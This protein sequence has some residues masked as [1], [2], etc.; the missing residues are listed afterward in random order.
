MNRS[1]IAL[2]C[3]AIE[4]ALAFVLP[5][6]GLIWSLFGV[7]QLF[8]RGHVT[9]ASVLEPGLFVGAGGAGFFGLF[10]MLRFL[11]TGTARLNR[12]VMSVCVLAGFS[13]AS[14]LAAD[15]VVGTND[16][17]FASVFIAPLVSG[18]HLLYL[19]RSYF[20]TASHIP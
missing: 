17:F 3:V 14:W 19:G 4:V 2:A 10:H 11:L 15:A 1:A 6:M 13:L 18:L 12:I 7:A 5:L 8:I 9:Q 16:W 20:R